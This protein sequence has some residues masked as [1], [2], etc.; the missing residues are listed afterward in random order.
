M[1]KELSIASQFVPFEL[2]VRLKELGFNEPS[3][4]CYRNAG[5]YGAN[6]AHGY[7]DNWEFKTNYDYDIY[8]INKEHPNYWVSAPTWQQAFDWFRENFNLLSC[9]GLQNDYQYSYEIYDI[10]KKDCV[11]YIDKIETYEEA[12]QDCL[13]QLI[14]IVTENK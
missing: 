6:I 14:E 5:L 3:I 10:K 11:D 9:I 12:R 4:M 1:E 8:M 13:E 2:A 7:V